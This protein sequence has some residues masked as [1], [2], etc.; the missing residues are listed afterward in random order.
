M[1]AVLADIDRW[2]DL[3]IFA[4]LDDPGDPAKAIRS[5]FQEVTT[6][7]RSGGRICLIGWMGLSSSNEAFAGRIR[8]YFHRWIQALDRCLKTGHVS[9]LE[10]R[11]LAEETVGGIQGAIILARALQEQAAFERIINRHEATLLCSLARCSR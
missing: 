10:A 7:F 4:P 1:A 9:P 2:F 5:M 3:V 6:Y 11:A 8:E